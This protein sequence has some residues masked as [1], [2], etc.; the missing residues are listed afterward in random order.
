MN[1]KFTPALQREIYD[2]VLESL[3][4]RPACDCSV[5]VPLFRGDR[6]VV[7]IMITGLVVAGDFLREVDQLLPKMRIVLSLCMASHWLGLD[8]HDVGV[9]WGPDRSASTEPGMVL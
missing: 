9:L 1:G 2:I 6:R 3:E 7:R 8:V 4:R 5:T